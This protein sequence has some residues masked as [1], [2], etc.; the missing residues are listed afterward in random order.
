MH[1]SEKWLPGGL[2]KP[3]EM[4][5]LPPNTVLYSVST[6]INNLHWTPLY[7]RRIHADVTLL[8]K[9]VNTLVAIPAIYYPTQ[10]LVR[11]TRLSHTLKFI[12]Y[13]C[14]LNIY[15]HSFFPRTV[16]HWNSLPES[17]VAAPSLGAFKRALHQVP[18]AEVF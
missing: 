16:T 14:R 13:Q 9:T 15:Q 5:S 6:M 17:T 12:P 8:Y 3:A 11:T 18:A 10:A 1:S 2:G 7:Q 4:G